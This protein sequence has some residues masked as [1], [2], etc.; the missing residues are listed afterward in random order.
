[1]KAC[2]FALNG[3]KDV[4]SLHKKSVEKYWVKWFYRMHCD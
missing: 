2:F 4:Y 3:F 1:M